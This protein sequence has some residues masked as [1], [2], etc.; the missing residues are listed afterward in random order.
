MGTNPKVDGKPTDSQWRH[1][2]QGFFSRLLSNLTEKSSIYAGTAFSANLSA[3]KDPNLKAIGYATSFNNTG[4]LCIGRVV[5][6][7]SETNCY[8]VDVEQLKTPVIAVPLASNS[9]S[10]IGATEIH[11]IS[12][13]TMVVVWVH[14][15]RYLS[16]ILGC[17]PDPG[18]VTDSS[19]HEYISALTRKG[20][21]DAH[22][23]PY[24]LPDS[25]QHLDM[26]GYRPIDSTMA[27]EWGASATTGLRV[28]LD[29]FMVQVAVN[30]F[31]GIFG[32]YH[33]QLLRVSGHNFQCWTAGSER[34]AMLDQGEYN[35]YQGYAPYGW[36]GVGLLIP[37]RDQVLEVPADAYL[38]P[39]SRPYWTHWE[40]KCEFQQPFHR[41]QEFYGYYG[42]GRRVVVSAP[43]KGVPIWSLK[44]GKSNSPDTPFLTDMPS[45]LNA[46]PPPC[47]SAPDKEQPPE[48]KPPYGFHEDN[49]AMDGRRFIASAKGV[50]I[51]KRMLIPVPTR[52]R[53]PE[54]GT[55]DKAEEN[56]RAGGHPMMGNGP[57]HTITGDIK[58]TNS[59]W[60]NLQR[61]CAVLDLHAYLF[62]Y[63]GLHPFHWH[64]K[65]Y[66]TWEQQELEYAENNH[67]VPTYSR[68][69]GS[70]YLGEEEF[71]TRQ[72]EVD[73]RYKT[74]KFF[75][76]ECFISLLEDGGVVI[77]DGYG[78]EIKM[79]A[80]VVQISAPGDVWFKAGRN[81]QA[82]AGHDV[83]VRAKDSVD[84]SSTEK[85]VR[86][87]AEQN[88]MIFAGN[89]TSKREGG[90]L[91][92]SRARKAIYQF[93]EP[94]DAVTFGGIVM[95]AKDA[96]IVGLARDIYFR[97]V[98]G[99]SGFGGRGGVITLDAARGEGQILTK[100]K[101]MFNYVGYDGGIWHI[102]KT[103]ADGPPGAFRTVGNRFSRKNTFCNGPLYTDKNIVADGSVLARG[104]FMTNK[105]HI[106]TKRGGPAT[107][108]PPGSECA[109]KIDEAV[110][111]I[112]DIINKILPE[113]AEE[114]DENAWKPL[115]YSEQRPGNNT[116][117]KEIEF[118][119][120][121]DEDY[122]VPDFELFED[123]WQQM[124]RETGQT[125][126]KWFEKPVKVITGLQTFPFPGLS[127]FRKADGFKR[128][129]WN[130]V[131]LK[132]KGLSDKRR[133]SGSGDLAAEYKNPEF[134]S[135]D[136]TS[137][138]A[139]YTIVG[140]V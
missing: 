15:A 105:G 84:I 137:L 106:I 130:M 114:I 65:D 16:W 18:S 87:K 70:M 4:H 100:S 109:V 94:G 120:R 115:W 99:A 110:Q 29:D 46:T 107:P 92:E 45:K 140:G 132:G 75:E 138:L 124:A 41:T 126:E 139:G 74:Q 135:T 119:F 37:G 23:K 69:R 136:E 66:K 95:K 81:V 24:L 103:E 76:S 20:V 112:N 93:K 40:N 102:F 72:I 31:T 122:R 27:S 39:K 21:D 86:I 43:P 19:R 90:I 53:R 33:D 125:L 83:I 48:Q 22:R 113:K 108:C 127:N 25:G 78:G 32:F 129:S 17:L 131:E 82:W 56:Y 58:S 96:E 44:P 118:S 101:D 77:G 80:G 30:E 36:E 3:Q 50:I 104:S 67:T 133:N 121:R 97:T 10:P 47:A 5:D 2:D 64:Y 57:E 98:G 134:K 14:D 6:G 71:Q 89:E 61:A 9:A 111:L 63:A 62:N 26:S 49:I 123:R 60:P 52:L 35:D 79:C 12:P 59:K 13:G 54:D 91:L 117:M 42:Q 68:L 128:Q 34:E 51:A 88:A 55:G 28:T 85:N 8:R 7:S 1:F 116:V 73:H 38:C 11:T